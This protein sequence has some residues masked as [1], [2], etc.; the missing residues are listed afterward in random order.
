MTQYMAHSPSEENPQWQTLKTHA[1]GV[2]AQLEHHLRYLT[3]PENV[4]ELAP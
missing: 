4:P 3:L 1:E 2:S